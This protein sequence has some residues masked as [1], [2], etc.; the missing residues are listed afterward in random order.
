MFQEGNMQF[1]NIQTIGTSIRDPYYDVHYAR[2]GLKYSRTNAYLNPGVYGT[3]LADEKPSYG[4]YSAL[5]APLSAGIVSEIDFSKSYLDKNLDP[6]AGLFT[7]KTFFGKASIESLLADMS[8]RYDMMNKNITAL[9]YQICYLDSEIMQ[10]PPFQ[11]G[12][13][14]DFDR[15]KTALEG[16]LMDLESE[17]M[18]EK[19]TAWKDI[20]RVKS[21][22][23]ECLGEYASAQGSKTFLNTAQG[24]QN[25]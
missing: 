10:L 15:T 2:Y 1:Q 14:K 8:L 23:M 19:T 20:N 16:K 11:M 13:F 12:L 21:D 17:K 5:L 3:L 22:L 24:D 7:Q 25:Y 4:D 6:V 9:D 18:R